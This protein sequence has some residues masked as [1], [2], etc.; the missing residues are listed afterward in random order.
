MTGRQ[1]MTK[2]KPDFQSGELTCACKININ[3]SALSTLF[4]KQS[5]QYSLAAV[6]LVKSTV[7]GKQLLGSSNS[8]QGYKAFSSLSNSNVSN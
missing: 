1:V 5:N 8:G 7:S 4:E 6:S 2:A 3:Y